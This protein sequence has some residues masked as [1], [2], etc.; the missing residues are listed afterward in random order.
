MSS[1]RE[2]AAAL[3]VM[4]AVTGLHFSRYFDLDKDISRVAVAPGEFDSDLTPQ[5]GTSSMLWEEALARGAVAH[6]NPYILAG[7]PNLANPQGR[8][9]ALENL[10]N[11]FFRGQVSARISIPIQ[12][13]IGWLGIFCLAR[14]LG[15]GAPQ[16]LIVGSVY[17]FDPVY[18][19][20]HAGTGHVNVINGTTFAPWLGAILVWRSLSTAGRIFGLGAVL[21]LMLHGGAIT[22]TAYAVAAL[23]VAYVVYWLPRGRGARVFLDLTA[24]FVVTAGLAWVKLAPALD[25][26]GVSQRRLGM[27]T[28]L[29]FSDELPYDRFTD[30]AWAV[31]LVGVF[32]VAGLVR[33]FQISRPWFAVCT[34]GTVLGLG[35]VFVEPVFA[36]VVENVPG[37]SR[38]R[39]PSRALFL[40]VLEIGLL[41]CLGVEWLATR[42]PLARA[43][44]GLRWTAAAGFIGMGFALAGPQSTMVDGEAE[45]EANPILRA[46]REDESFF[47][48]TSYQD[49]NR[50]WGYQHQTIPY[51]IRLLF[52]YTPGYANDFIY[53]R[54]VRSVGGSQHPFVPRIFDNYAT[55]TGL[56]S[57]KYVSSME[58]LAV[59]GLRHLATFA[60][61]SEPQPPKSRG[62][63]L[64]L[65]ERSLPR[66]YVAAETVAVTGSPDFVAETTLSILSDPRFRP[67]RFSLIAAPRTDDASTGIALEHCD[68]ALAEGSTDGLPAITREQLLEGSGAPIPVGVSVYERSPEELAVAVPPDARGRW[69]VLSEKFA[70]FRGWE[71]AARTRAGAATL[72]LVRANH[73]D[74]AVWIPPETSGSLR[75]SYVSPGYRLGLVML[76]ATLAVMLGWGI[77]TRRR[78]RPGTGSI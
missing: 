10:L 69:I 33:L 71:A 35:Y 40:L 30:H 73:V 64:Y 72:P 32:V 22:V 4:I 17:L 6:W 52:G 23:T 16:A 43:S 39:I 15:W 31:A 76:F 74:T 27:S 70:L 25:F 67:E 59:P 44:T 48:L 3:I 57:V 77:S 50:H 56:L 49:R 62:P 36:F 45:R 8:F 34:A 46:V 13:L 14:Q 2:L 60:V 19:A 20:Y 18:M 37:L 12:I 75:L 55:M 9:I 78:D 5:F 54:Y 53:S 24:V 65:N 7:T 68:R 1:G 41:T 63:Y 58:P 51:G 42:R 66:A 61:A 21:A 26:I 38:M 47:R 28:R 29:A 11:L